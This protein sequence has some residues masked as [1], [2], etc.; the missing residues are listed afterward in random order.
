VDFVVEGVGCV[1][2]LSDYASTA[3]ALQNY[4]NVC[5]DARNI[6]SK[7]IENAKVKNYNYSSMADVRNA[8][9]IMKSTYI[10]YYD[11]QIKYEEGFLLGTMA[12]DK[13]YKDYLEYERIK[14]QNLQLGEAYE[15]I[16][17]VTYKERFGK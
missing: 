12:A 3:E 15:P 17:Y 6:Y 4:V 2:G 9:E 5:S 10:A 13:N 16:S 14:L 1:T 7:A 8:F 11:A